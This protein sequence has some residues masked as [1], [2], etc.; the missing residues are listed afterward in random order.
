[1]ANRLEMMRETFAALSWTERDMAQAWVL[2]SLADS[3]TEEQ[4]ARALKEGLEIAQQKSPPAM[5]RKT[6]STGD[7]EP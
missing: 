4:W 5:D 3:A 6:A 7:R 1:M 2:K